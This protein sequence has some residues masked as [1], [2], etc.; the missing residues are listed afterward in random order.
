MSRKFSLV[1][2]DAIVTARKA[3]GY[4]TRA[5]F[6]RERI[7]VTDEP[8]SRDALDRCE[9]SPTKPH[10]ALDSTLEKLSKI[11]NVS[12]DSLVIPEDEIAG[13]PVKIRD[14][15]GKWEITG[16]DI[17]VK[18]HFEYPNGPK[19]V[20]G[21]IDIK[22]AGTVVKAEGDFYDG[23]KIQFRGWLEEG[24]DHLIGTYEILNKRMR[25]YGT[26]NLQYL[27][28]GKR[29]KGWYLG[30]ETGHGLPY[31][32]GSLELTLLEEISKKK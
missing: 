19:P 22:T 31:I 17:V 23:D 12:K 10:H 2:G 9:Q 3:M 28:C 6:W 13:G 1:N 20:G 26:I 30:R 24:G 25:I 16:G 21:T 15:S 27:A 8:I 14:C 18:E 5:K 11:L 29:M 7:A 4:P 32:L